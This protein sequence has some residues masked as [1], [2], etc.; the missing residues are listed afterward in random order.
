VGCGSQPYKEYFSDYVGVDMPGLTKRPPIEADAKHLPFKN[1]SFDSILCLEVLEHVD[2]PS[3]V[4]REMARVLKKGG[5]LY[6]T[7]PMYWYVHYA[8]FD[9]WRFTCYSLLALCQN[10]GLVVEYLNRTGG[11]NYFI[12]CRISE[13]LHVRLPAWVMKVIDRLLILYARLDKYNYRD[14]AGWV[15]RAR[16]V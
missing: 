5:V 9:F 15:L 10:H 16:R 2:S 1:A 6:L 7:V 8:P 13:S 4:M 3:K 11:L 14:A 12:A